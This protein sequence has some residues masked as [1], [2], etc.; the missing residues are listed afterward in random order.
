MS[1]TIM[2]AVDDSVFLSSVVKLL[3]NW[4]SLHL[5]ADQWSWLQDKHAHISTGAPLRTVFSAF[6]AVPR[7]TRKATISLSPADIQQSNRLCEGWF[8]QFWSLDQLGRAFLLLS[9]PHDDSIA[10]G[11]SLDQLFASADV[12]ELIALYQALPLLPH[13]TQHRARAAEGIRSNMTSVFN[14]IALRNPYPARYLDDNA[15]NQLVLKAMFVGSPLHLIWGLDQ[16]INP[17]LTQMAIDYAH[18]RWAAKRTVT[19][20]LWRLVGQFANA[21]LKPDLERALNDLDSIQ[22]AA[23]ALACA[24]SPSSEIRSLLN[25]H[26]AMQQAIHE[27]RLTWHH[28]AEA[29]V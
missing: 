28:V 4:L 19:P 10:Y 29:K 16:R 21:E 1:I 27:G 14:A 13:P 9:L 20:E 18:E 6:S 26:P 3:Q 5:S 17:A 12:G 11:R 2:A 25:H 15:W 23:A 7:Y 8:P 22:Q 24:Q